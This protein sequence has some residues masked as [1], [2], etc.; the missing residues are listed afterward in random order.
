MCGAQESNQGHLAC[1]PRA[2]IRSSTPCLLQPF[3]G[4]GI[5]TEQSN[6]AM[7]LKLLDF[8]WLELELSTWLEPCT[9]CL[10]L[11]CRN[12]LSYSSFTIEPIRRHSKRCNYTRTDSHSP[13][14]IPDWTLK[15]RAEKK[16]FNFPGSWQV[17]FYVQ[18]DK[19]PS[20]FHSF[21]SAHQQF[22]EGAFQIPHF[23][24]TCIGLTCHTNI[25]SATSPNSS[26]WLGHFNYLKQQYQL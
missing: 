9:M 22:L 23:F 11:P 21:L 16:M 1:Q 12:L 6:K 2:H 7:L 3:H 14:P 19:F 15:A 10:H 5:Y 20:K 26:T 17:F 13:H 25:F 24:S 4:N 18:E 8:V